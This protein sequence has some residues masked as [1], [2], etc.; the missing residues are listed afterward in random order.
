MES[1]VELIPYQALPAFTEQRAHIQE[2][3]ALPSDSMVIRRTE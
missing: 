1:K 3:E 2:P